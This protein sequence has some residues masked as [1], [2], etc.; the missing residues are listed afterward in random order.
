MNLPDTL[1]DEGWYWAAWLLWIPLTARLI[2]RAPWAAL[3]DSPRFNLWLGLIVGL[4]VIWSLKAGI[5]PGLSLHLLGASVLTLSFGPAL[6]FIGLC[7]VLAAVTL[8]AG[9]SWG[10]FALNALLMGGCGVLFADRI[11]KLADRCLPR[12]FFVYVFVNGFF[13]AAL[14]VFGVGVVACLLLALAGAY[15]VDYLVE[16]YLPYYLLLGFS[17]AW[18]SGM[19][20]TLLIVYFPGWVATFDDSRY[21]AGK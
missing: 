3:R 13:G 18:L 11:F 1:L 20:M 17:E 10:S 21:L 5:K 12:H 8:N 9:D 6:A 7:V 2:W 19:A 4:C 15:S 14:T 16:E